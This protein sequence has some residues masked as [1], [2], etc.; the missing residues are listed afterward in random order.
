[1]RKLLILL[2]LCYYG[3]A[4]IQPVESY[5]T[6]TGLIVCEN[7]CTHEQGHKL[8]HEAGWISSTDEF[9]QSV[10]TYTWSQSFAENK[11]AAYYVVMREMMTDSLSFWK[12]AE[13]YAEIYSVA[14]GNINNIP[15]FLR[16]YYR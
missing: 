9:K 12:Y 8:D 10:Q 6:V 13:I 2:I 14:E 3:M 7:F 11:D 5:N 16:D 15:L 1:M 4:Y